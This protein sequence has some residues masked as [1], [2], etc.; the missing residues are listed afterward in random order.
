MFTARNMSKRQQQKKKKKILV[1]GQNQ[2][3]KEIDCDWINV[4]VNNVDSSH[5]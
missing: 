4:Q 2:K 5:L 3:N 1:S